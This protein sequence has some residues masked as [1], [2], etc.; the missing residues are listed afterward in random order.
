MSTQPPA[1]SR[2]WSRPDPGWAWSESALTFG[3]ASL[4][5]RP[6]DDRD[7]VWLAYD[8]VT[9]VEEL[10]EPGPHGHIVEVAPS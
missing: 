8:A 9:D 4:L 3:D 5:V 7:D 10:G 2:C 6:A 1:D